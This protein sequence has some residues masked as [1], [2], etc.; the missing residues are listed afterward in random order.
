VVLLRLVLVAAV[1]A[2]VPSQATRRATVVSADVLVVAGRVVADGTGDPIP[3]ARVT[4]S[5]ES[6]NTPV[7]LTDAAGSFHFTTSS[8]RFNLVVSKTG[9]ARADARPVV[10]GQL[11]DVRLKKGAVIV[12]RVVDEHGDPVVGVQVAALKKSGASGKPTTVTTIDTDDRGEYR[13][14][15]LSDGDVVLGVTTL[16]AVGPALNPSGNRADPK[17]TYYPGTLA[18]DEAEA[19]HL[20]SGSERIVADMVIPGD[21]L[22]GMPAALFENRFRPR[23]ESPRQLLLSPQSP[24]PRPTG[25]VRGRVMNVDGAPISLA[26]VYLFGSSNADSKMAT[27]DQDGRF[28]VAGVVA[29]TLL[30]SVFKTGYAQVESG[31]A[32]EPFA[33]GR[34]VTSPAPND[35]QFGRRV[36]LAA[37]ENRSVELQMARRGTLS[38]TVTDEYG[39]HIQGVGVEVLRV[40]YEGGRRRLVS[41]GA[42]SLTDDLGRYRLHGLAP[43]RYIVSATVGQVASADIP[44]YSRS[45]FPGTS[46]AGDARYVSVG[47][48]QDIGFVD[49]SL[50]RAPTVRVAGTVLGPSGEP[51]APGA[52]TLVP[53]QWS[54]SVTSVAVGAR[55]AGDGTF[56][57]PNVP[58]GQYVIQAYR[59]PSNPHTEGEFG[60]VS[61]TVGS[62]EVSGVVV[63]TSTGS[64]VTGRFS[65]NGNQRA[66]AKPSDFEL[67]AIPTDLDLSPPGHPASARI[68]DDWT[69]EM[70]GLNGPR[71][72]QL[73]RTAPGLAVE[74]I[75]VN[76]ADETDRPIPFGARAQSLANVEV[77]L[78]DR[79]SVLSGRVVD[80]RARPVVGASV[81]VCS[82]DRQLWYASS[83]YLRHSQTGQD[84]GFSVTGLPAGSYYAT[85]VARIPTDGEGAW[86]DRQFLESLLP[87]ASAITIADG[88]EAALTLRLSSR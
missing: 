37:D 71:R 7:V 58:P 47:L 27:T 72:L 4:L 39:D 18:V 2:L 25:A 32:L 46:N 41:A 66:T 14:A 50:S 28:E 54:S 62:A 84:G 16:A 64:S 63:R 1:A 65:F 70:S 45:Y 59:G 19:L 26:R 9:Y 29:G 52:L 88:Q 61:V 79:V 24:A 40:Q 30:V 31:E 43:G 75:L 82:A 21:R 38:G 48:A 49:F 67:T 73:V 12:G 85:A 55:I 8:G 35:I 56:V 53:S 23:P 83:R 33:M 36:E 68:R 5:P 69:F 60:A 11:T 77:V 74:K 51:A 57:F 78:T 42:A 6:S 87:G 44:G 20:Q 80:D 34:A 15:G 22:A 81:I 86:Q 76:G 3:N 17:T 10:A 13:L